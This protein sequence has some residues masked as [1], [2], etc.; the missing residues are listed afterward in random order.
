MPPAPLPVT[1]AVILAAGDG[2]RLGALTEDTPKPLVELDG[3]PIIAYT[4]DAL[5]SAGISEVGV[6]VGYRREQ[7][8][9]GL[10]AAP[11]GAIAFTVLPNP[12]FER[13]ASYSLAAA[14]EFAG[15]E[16]FLLV[17]ADHILS[18]TL[19]S[20]LLGHANGATLV[21]A[22]FARPGAHTPAY[23]AEATKLAVDSAGYV[24]AIGKAVD[25]WDALD[26]G[27]FLCTADIWP[28][29]DG[30]PA[31]CELSAIFSMLVARRSLRAA[32]VTGA[33][34]YD[35]DTAADLAAAAELLPGALYG[36]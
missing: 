12:Y 33:F 20:R 10:H 36:V 25:P 35:I 14:R 4:L 6:V 16:P 26:T 5:A 13:G 34:W 29:L 7:V 3:R 9:A 31:D 19:I 1:R 8:E 2:G 32:D 24:S 17:M 18:D 11:H 28:A 23:V 15:S 22:D 30:A 21:G 27:A